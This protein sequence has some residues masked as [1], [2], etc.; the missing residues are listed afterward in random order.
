MKGRAADPE[1]VDVRACAP[2]ASVDREDS[3][4]PMPYTCEF[5]GRNAFGGMVIQRADL[6]YNGVGD[7]TI[8][9]IN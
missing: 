6:V 1:S 8:S 4:V 5:A 2:D 9:R 3:V 7:A